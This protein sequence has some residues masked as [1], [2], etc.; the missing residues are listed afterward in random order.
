M[1]EHR[2]PQWTVR[3]LLSA[4]GALVVLPLSLVAG[5]PARAAG[6]QAC[7]LPVVT[8]PLQEPVWGFTRLRPD[9]AW[10]LTRGAGVT[11]AVIDSGVSPTHPALA[12]KVLTGRDFLL[13]S[14]GQC[15]EN[16]HGTL[17]AG[18]IAGRATVS[19]GYRFAG[20]APDATILPVRVL[21]DEQRSSDTSL[22]D[23]IA[24][25]IGWAVDQGAEVINMS[26]T[27]APSPK[28]ETAI[29]SALDAGVVLVAAAGNEGGTADDG[30]VAY[31]AAYD[32]VIAVAG[33]DQQDQRVSSSSSGDYVDVA[34]P[35][36]R[37]SGPSAAGA[38]FLYSEAG[39]TS[40]AAAYVSGVAALVRANNR[41][42]S[43]EEVADRIMLT[44]S[45]GRAWDPEIGH[46]VVDPARAVGVLT[47][48]TALAPQPSGW[49]V[50]PA[51]AP[52][53]HDPV[54]AAAPWVVGAGALAAIA[55]LVAVPI[56]RRG[57]QRGWHP[58]QH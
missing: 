21:R 3:L 1:A 54:G 31:P 51:A 11:V 24:D 55:V 50:P 19:N 34:A 47:V 12:G 2:A 35:G 9:L 42:L 17:V 20:V 14:T 15:D 22:S 4:V 18:I 44:A 36:V 58:G 56:T 45:Q 28:L 49:V 52:M 5:L 53:Q 7:N 16:G 57:R 10:P 8:N 27:T 48:A 32:G 6:A 43:P 41:S 30:Q 13:D 38:G 23:R 46:G 40:F 39:G 26:L 25:A 33:T 29:R 37:I